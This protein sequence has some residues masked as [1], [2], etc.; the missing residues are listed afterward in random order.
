MVGIGGYGDLYVSRLLDSNE[1]KEA[2]VAGVVDINPKKSKNYHKIIE[3]QIPVFT[4]IEEFYNNRKAD[5]AVISTPI[6]L[7]AYQTCYALNHGSNVLCEKP[8]CTTTN[9]AYSMIQTRNETNKFL[10]IGFNWSFNPSIQALK[11]DIA[12]GL[13]GKPRRLKTILLWP[14]T[15]KYFDRAPWA[16]KKYGENGEQILDSVA[17]NAGAH[18]LHHMFYLLGHKQ[19]ESARLNQVT[20]ELY[21]ANPIE[22]FDTC[23]IKANTDEGVEV[24][25]YATHA[26]KDQAGPSFTFEFE[27]ATITYTQGAGTNNVVA[28]FHDGSKKVYPDPRTEDPLQKLTKCIEA[29]KTGNQNIYCG[30]EAAF[31]HTLCINSIHN[32][33]SEI[34]NFPKEI[35]KHDKKTDVIWAEGLSDI[36]NKC[37]DESRMPSELD[38]TWAREGKM[39]NI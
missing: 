19:E 9:D 7:H 32:S 37:F 31:T 23:A 3:N 14:R 15:K 26:V 35:I 17:N 8:M 38:I 10:A 12:S 36:L 21:R 2:T 4:S 20:A 6:H 16:G 28:E 30:P 27:F 1:I 13:F 29:I 24:L 5:L 25:Y 22:N 34:I 11:K 39:I 33:M 18:Y